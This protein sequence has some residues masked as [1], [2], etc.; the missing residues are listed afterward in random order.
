ME[1]V[2]RRDFLKQTALAGGGLL[3]GQHLLTDGSGSGVTNALALVP[4]TTAE[5]VALRLR[6]NGANYGLRLDPRVS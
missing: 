3:L 1:D 6:V 4:Q 2:R 5:K